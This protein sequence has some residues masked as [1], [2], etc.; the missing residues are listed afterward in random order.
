MSSTDSLIV[1]DDAYAD[2]LLRTD[3]FHRHRVPLAMHHEVDACV[4]EPHVARED[5]SRKR[6]KIGLCRQISLQ[7]GSNVNPSAAR[8]SRIGVPAAHWGKR[9]TRDRGS[10]PAATALKS[11]K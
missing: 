8:K 10:A 11:T 6:W 1:I 4:A 5:V 2:H 7:A 9:A 3:R